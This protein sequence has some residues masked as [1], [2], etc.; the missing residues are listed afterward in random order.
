MNRVPMTTFHSFVWLGGKHRNCAHTD[1]KDINQQFMW[2]HK[3]VV[4]EIL[5]LRNACLLLLPAKWQYDLR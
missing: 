1:C 4:L 3:K 5:I 2:Q